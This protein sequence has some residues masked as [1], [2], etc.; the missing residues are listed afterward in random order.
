MA[1]QIGE[2]S[3]AELIHTAA[4]GYEHGDAH[5]LA[6]CRMATGPDKGVCNAYGEVFGYP[7]LFVSDGASIP[8]GT[9]VNPAE[10]IAANAERIADYIVQNR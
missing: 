9:G 3:N 2:A 5:P 1:K 8:G 7:R 10:T 6:T 4:D